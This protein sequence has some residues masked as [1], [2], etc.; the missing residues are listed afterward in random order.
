M[1]ANKSSHIVSEDKIECS[2]EET[3]TLRTLM[4]NILR[5]LLDDTYMQQLLKE[6]K[7]EKPVIFWL[8]GS[9]F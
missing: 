5:T 9:D 1:K 7:D 2:S 8:T 4:G 6:Q 3:R